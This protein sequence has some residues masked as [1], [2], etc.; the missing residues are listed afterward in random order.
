MFFAEVRL[1]KVYASYHL[2][3]LYI[4][5]SLQA[6]SPELAKR[7]QGKTCFNF[8]K[9]VPPELLAELRDLTERGITAY[10][11]KYPGWDATPTA[12]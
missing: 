3:A 11:E 1:G 8:K 10:N 9:E 2:M 4:D 5:T 7:K 12:S 6:V